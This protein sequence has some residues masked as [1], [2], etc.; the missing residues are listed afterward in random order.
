MFGICLPNYYICNRNEKKIKQENINLTIFKEMNKKL[1]FLAIAALGLAAC[2]NDDVVE[3]NQGEAINFRPL[4]TNVTRA[5][6]ASFATGTSFKVTAFEAGATSNAY[7]TN[8]VFTASEGTTFTSTYKHYWPSAYNLDFYAW[9]PS[10]LSATTDNYTGFEITPST[11]QVSD[12]IDFVYAVTRGWGKHDTP[13]HDGTS[14][15]T[16]NFRHA[17][18]KVLVQLKNT[19]DNLKITVGSVTIGNLR[20]TETFTWNGVTDGTTSTAANLATTDGKYTT[21]E[22]TLSYLNGTWTATSAQTAAYAVVMGQDNITDDKSTSSARNVFNGNQPTA[23]DLT[24]TAKN[25]EMILIPQVLNPQTTYSAATPASTFAGAYI[26]VQIKIQNKAN[27]AYIVGSDGD[28]NYVT[29]MWPL[30][31]LT[32]LPGHKYTYTVD[33]AGGGYFTTNQD[34]S[35]DLDPILEGAEIKFVTVTVDDWKDGT[36]TG[37]YTGGL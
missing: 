10:T 5:T 37:V 14:G 36:G 9:Q 29:A 20:G 35:D 25:H 1:F 16:I 2:S 24:A 22:G 13:T 8:E 34:S 33:L 26:Q 7:F 11:T 18:S 12:Q 6:D 19:N 4:V 31:A 28:Q 21:G 32:W 27:S 30:T 3:I 23:R 17:E 15:V